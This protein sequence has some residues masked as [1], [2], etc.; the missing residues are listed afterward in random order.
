MAL[1]QKVVGNCDDDD[2]DGDDDVTVKISHLISPEQKMVRKSRLAGSASTL[3]RE[4]C[5]FTVVLYLTFH[6]YPNPNT[7]YSDLVSA[8]YPFACISRASTFYII[9][10]TDH[11]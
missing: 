8:L 6:L 11:G 10:L 2:N 3:S 7:C 5:L 4:K 9:L 1:A